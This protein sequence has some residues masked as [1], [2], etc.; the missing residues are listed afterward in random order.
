MKKSIV[1]IFI[2]FSSLIYAQTNFTLNDTSFIEKQSLTTYEISFDFDK[3]TLRPSS[4]IFLDS[5]ANFL[6]KNDSIILEVRNHRDTRGPNYYS[7]NITQSRAQAVVNYL[8]EKGI[9]RERL[10]PKGYGD[11]MPLVS[12][13][14]IA[15]MKSKEEQEKAH[16]KNRR[17]E[18]VILRI[19]FLS[20]E[21]K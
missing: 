12:D 16:Q 11:V 3:Y 14:E 17:M 21:K 15:K 1:F 5:L 9:E 4:N 20:P 10:I 18:F 8:I 19:D 7:R 2:L 13:Q 6:Q